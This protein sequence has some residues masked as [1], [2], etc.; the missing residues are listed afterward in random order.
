[1]E[2]RVEQPDEVLINGELIVSLLLLHASRNPHIVMHDVEILRKKI[3]EYKTIKSRIK[4]L[5]LSPNKDILASNALQLDI[6][7]KE[8]SELNNSFYEKYKIGPEAL[9]YGKI[10]SSMINMLVECNENR[11][12]INKQNQFAVTIVNNVCKKIKEDLDSLRAMIASGVYNRQIIYTWYNTAIVASQCGRF[13]FEN[14]TETNFSKFN[15]DY[16]I[17]EQQCQR[18]YAQRDHLLQ[19]TNT[20]TYSLGG[21]PTRKNK[22]KSR[23]RGRR[24]GRKSRSTSTRSHRSRKY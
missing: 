11:D 4:I 9:E 3:E 17:F 10:M 5:Q 12:Q 15:H 2:S 1:M 8:L 23:N 22:K 18:E 20:F 21:K 13:A 6:Q 24:S 7:R 16:N 19:T 14:R